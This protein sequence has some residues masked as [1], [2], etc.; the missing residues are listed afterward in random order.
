MLGKRGYARDAKK[1]RKGVAG[2]GQQTG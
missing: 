2:V 1:A